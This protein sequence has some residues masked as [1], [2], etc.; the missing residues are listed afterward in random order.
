MFCCSS[1]E[2]RSSA[3]RQDTCWSDLFYPLMDVNPADSQ[4]T[5]LGWA[6]LISV[7][8]VVGVAVA[9]PFRVARQPPPL[10]ALNAN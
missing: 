6:M 9:R 4:Q 2:E 7:F 1:Y 5:T 8:I 3:C 10:S